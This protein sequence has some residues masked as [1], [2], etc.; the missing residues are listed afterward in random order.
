MQGDPNAPS[1]EMGFLG[2]FSPLGKLH[3]SRSSSSS[4]QGLPAGQLSQASN[5]ICQPEEPWEKPDFQSDCYWILFVTF[6]EL[7]RASLLLY[8][9]L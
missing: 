7:S 4:S 6:A 8:L 3:S 9:L 2:D 5:P 1:L